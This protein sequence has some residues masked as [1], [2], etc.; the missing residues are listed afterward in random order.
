MASLLGTCLEDLY[1]SFKTKLKYLLISNFPHPVSGD[2]IS[3]YFLCVPMASGSGPQAFEQLEGKD[4]ELT[5]KDRFRL[6][7]VLQD[8]LTN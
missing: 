6:K 8:Q 7:I 3:W 5:N 1:S 4:H 2:T